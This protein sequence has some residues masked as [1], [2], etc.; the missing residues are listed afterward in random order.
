MPH[1]SCD[2]DICLLAR[3]LTAEKPNMTRETLAIVNIL[4]ARM[5]A[6]ETELAWLK[7]KQSEGEAEDKDYDPEFGD[8]RVCQCGHKY[9]RH[10]DSYE[11]MAPV[12]CKYCACDEFVEIK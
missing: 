3:R 12:G 1:K 11:D 9:H 2:C 10:F 6:A 5:E 8:E 4:W 7:M